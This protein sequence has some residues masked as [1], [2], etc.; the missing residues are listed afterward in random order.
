M[1]AC[2]PMNTMT[3]QSPRRG[4]WLQRFAPGPTDLLRDAVAAYLDTHKVAR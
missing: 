3:N 1:A 4:R 2:N